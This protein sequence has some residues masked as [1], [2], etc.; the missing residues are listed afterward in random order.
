MVVYYEAFTV[1]VDKQKEYINRIRE[2]NLIDIFRKQRGNIYYSVARS[3]VEKDT[4]IIS[5][6]WETEDDFQAHV[7]SQEVKEWHDIYNLYVIDSK[8]KEYHFN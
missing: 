1:S 8:K 6:A 7:E 3:I 2:S 4:I 5:D